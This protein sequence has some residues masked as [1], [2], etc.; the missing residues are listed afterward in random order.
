VQE[1]VGIYVKQENGDWWC[2]VCSMHVS[3]KLKRGHTMKE[4]HKSGIVDKKIWLPRQEDLGHCVTCGVSFGPLYLVGHVISLHH[5][6][7]H[8][9]GKL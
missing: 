6:N 1:F 4:S 3:D 8:P 2:S 5:R 7:F 9:E